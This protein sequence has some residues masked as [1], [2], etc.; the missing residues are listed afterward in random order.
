MKYV[1]KQF[2]GLNKFAD[3]VLRR[4]FL[5]DIVVPLLLLLGICLKSYK[6]VLCFFIINCF[7]TIEYRGNAAGVQRGKLG[8]IQREYRGKEEG[9]QRE[10]KNEQ[11]RRIPISL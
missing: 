5:F 1:A 3:I 2:P 11:N 7:H 4:V 6:F 10:Y 8:K 9:K